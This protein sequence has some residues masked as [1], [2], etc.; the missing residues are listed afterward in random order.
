MYFNIK[1]EYERDIFISGWM[2]IFMFHES[3]IRLKVLRYGPLELNTQ[4]IFG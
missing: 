2:L 4:L 3:L 1:T